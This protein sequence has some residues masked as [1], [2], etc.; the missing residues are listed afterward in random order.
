MKF[1]SR[2]VKSVT[3]AIA[4]AA[5]M[6]IALGIPAIFFVLSYEYVKASMETEVRQISLAVSRRANETPDLWQYERNHL[7]ALIAGSF[8]G[9]ETR[10]TRVVDLSGALIVETDMNP[11]APL[12]YRSADILETGKTAGRIEQAQTIRPLLVRTGLVALV[13]VFFAGLIFW[14]L[15]ALPIRALDRALAELE[16]EQAL[17]QSHAL[18]LAETNQMLDQSNQ[19]LEKFNSDVIDANAELTRA[20][21]EA[22]VAVE[23]KAMFL[24]NMSHEIRTPLNGVIGMT[25]LLTDTAL[26]RE[27]RDF[28]ETIRVSGNGLLAV[29]NDILDFS[30]IESGGI[31]LDPRDVEIAVVIEE[32]FDVL[33][34]KAREKR[35]DLMYLIEP[36]VP[37]FVKLDNLRLSQILLNLVS[38]AIKFTPRGQVVVSVKSV[39]THAEAGLSTL[40]FSVKDS[41]IGIEADKLH[42]LFKPFSQ[43]DGSTTRL[44]GGT[45][46]GLAIS[47]RLSEIMG[48]GISVASEPGVGSTFSFTVFA[49]TAAPQ[50]RTYLKTNIPN[51]QGR[52]VLILD[53][54]AVNR[55]VLA[56]QCL[57]WGMVPES[58]ADPE[59][60]LTRIRRGEKF[61]IGII[62]MM[63]P[64]MNGTD[65]AAAA[66][67]LVPPNSLPMLLLSS[68]TGASEESRLQAGLFSVTL[69]KPLKQSLLFNGLMEV[70]ADAKPNPERDTPAAEIDSGLAARLPLR[71]L[72]AEDNE[73]NQLVITR[74]LARLGYTAHIAEDGEAA[75]SLISSS[76]FDI[77]FMD[78]QMPVMDGLTATRHIRANNA[79]ANKPIIIAMTADAMAE[80]RERCLAA[81]MDDYVPKPI[82]PKSVAAALVKWGDKLA[83]AKGLG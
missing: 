57:R 33:A 66:R 30:K 7:R 28:V 43:V 62:D 36:G 5:A 71:I 26:S 2:N 10:V 74:I 69:S 1:D 17:V 81:G 40:E 50:P 60:A 68:S 47:R 56:A 16:R 6:V 4:A 37:P 55:D 83:G 23:A 63:M 67:K 53:D 58:V 61:D 25:D 29:I 22:L 65:F 59:E 14:L 54:N 35:L 9:D 51:L 38:N 46:L 78:L 13:S 52:R 76:T 24:A 27:Q 79:I 3:T 12:V 21:R 20:N 18:L 31:E 70:M 75:L 72:V 45:G 15:R 8:E 44:Y 48:G 41:G 49:E 11:A 39:E 73:L 34:A 82:S 42:R 77:V 19:K 80:D 32:A 64:G